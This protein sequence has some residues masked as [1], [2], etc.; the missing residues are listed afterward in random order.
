MYFT[1]SSGD[2]M[3][4]QASGF[5]LSA[6]IQAKLK[7]AKAQLV[8]LKSNLPLHISELII[9]LL[10]GCLGYAITKMRRRGV[11]FFILSGVCALC[12]VLLFIAHNWL[13]GG[14]SFLALMLAFIRIIQ[15]TKNGAVI[16]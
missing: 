3:I 2:K 14:I 12:I 10:S 9:G 6:D 1:L 7:M 16:L 8:E 5:A 13:L 4:D 11:A 15:L